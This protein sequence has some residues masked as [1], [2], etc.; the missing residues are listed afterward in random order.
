ML[1][2]VV[3][4][5]RVVMRC[6]GYPRLLMGRQRQQQQQQTR[7]HHACLLHSQ[8]RPAV[9]SPVHRVTTLATTGGVTRLRYKITLNV[10]ENTIVVILHSAVA[11]GDAEKITAAEGW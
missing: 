7:H 9:I 1:E 11:T 5:T 3:R 8:W 2:G 10:V 6:A 4:L